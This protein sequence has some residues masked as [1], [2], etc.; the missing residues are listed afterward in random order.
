R[1]FVKVSLLTLCTVAAVLLLSGLFIFSTPA[2]MDW[3]AHA[4]IDAAGSRGDVIDFQ[5]YTREEFARIRLN[6]TLLPDDDFTHLFEETYGGENR[7]ESLLLVT[8]DVPDPEN[9]QIS[10]LYGISR[11]TDLVYSNTRWVGRPD[12][13]GEGA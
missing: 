12:P 7:K 5:T 1:R 9:R 10:T 8:Y 3:Y 2:G 13:H 4:L 6:T 11:Y